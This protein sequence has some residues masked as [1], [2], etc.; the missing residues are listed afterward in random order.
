MVDGQ[1]ENLECESRRSNPPSTMRWYLGDTELQAAE[2]ASNE[3]EEGDPRRWRTVSRLRHKFAKTDYG[4]PVTC[5]VEHPAYSTG[6]RDATVVLDVLCES[7]DS[8]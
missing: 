7:V 1:I 6:F 8:I 2:E 3:T 5:R 4:K